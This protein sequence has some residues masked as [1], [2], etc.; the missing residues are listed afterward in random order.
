MLKCRMMKTIFDDQLEGKSPAVVL[1]TIG[2]LGAYLMNMHALA[3]YSWNLAR[4]DDD[5]FFCGLDQRERAALV[6]RTKRVDKT[7]VAE[8]TFDE[9]VLRLIA[10][11]PSKTM[12]ALKTRYLQH[13]PRLAL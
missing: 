4:S 1:Q 6:E 11:G 8:N 10:D 12:A 9:M 13:E 5:V 7:R 2:A 3:S